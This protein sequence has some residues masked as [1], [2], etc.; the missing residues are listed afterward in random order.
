M[1]HSTKEHTNLVNRSVIKYIIAPSRINSSNSHRNS[2]AIL[3]QRFW[4]QHVWKRPT[5]QPHRK[6]VIRAP[7]DRTGSFSKSNAPAFPSPLGL[8]IHLS[9]RTTCL[10][11]ELVAFRLIPHFIEDILVLSEQQSTYEQWTIGWI[12]SY[13]S[14]HSTKSKLLERYLC[15]CHRIRV[16]RTAGGRKPTWV[17]KQLKT[18]W[19]NTCVI[20]RLA[21]TN[22]RVGCRMG[23]S[24]A[25]RQAPT[26]CPVLPASKTANRETE[27]SCPMKPY[28]THDGRCPKFPQMMT[29][30]GSAVEQTVSPTRV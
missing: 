12:V 15:N 3:V 27:I 1:H 25:A 7:G 11:F 16:E 26:P 18:E 17:S 5:N 19:Q 14:C 24:L 2:P 28:R 4:S 20:W 21:G 22:V 8:L 13:K 10:R 29:G 23:P 30:D 6:K 9:R